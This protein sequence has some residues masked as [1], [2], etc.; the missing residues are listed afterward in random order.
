MMMSQKPLPFE[1]SVLHDIKPPW[2]KF[3]LCFL[4]A[5][6]EMNMSMFAKQ[7]M[8]IFVI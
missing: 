1:M 8:S 7:L 2:Q 4:S 6:Y 5:E 3:T